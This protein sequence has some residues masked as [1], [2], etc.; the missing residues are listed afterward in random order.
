[1]SVTTAE[2]PGIGSLVVGLNWTF[3][4]SQLDHAFPEPGGTRRSREDSKDAAFEFSRPPAEPA[5]QSR[6]RPRHGS[7]P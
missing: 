1:M 2:R 3:A 5:G 6:T 7:G 4:G